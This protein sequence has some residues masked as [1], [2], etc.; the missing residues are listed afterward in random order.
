VTD[1]SARP[2]PRG[3]LRTHAWLIVLAMVVTLGGA[4]VVAFTRP[5]SYVAT[6]QVAVGPELAGG[7][8]LRPEM[9]SEREIATSGAVTARAANLLGVQPTDAAAGLSVSVVIESSILNIRYTAADATAASTG[10]S[11]FAQSYVDYRNTLGTGPRIARVVTQADVVERSGGN[12]PL[13]FGVALVA[14]LA[15]GVGAAWLWDR[16]ADRVRDPEELTERSG[17][18]VLAR[19]PRWSSD[20]AIAPDGPPGEAFGYVAARLSA[21]TSPRRVGVRIVVTSPRSG[22]GT[23]TVAMNTAFALAAQGRKVVLVDANLRNP[24]LHEVVG[25]AEAPGLLDVLGAECN[26]DSALRHLRRPLVDVLPIGGS[27]GARPSAPDIDVLRIILGQLGSRAVVVVDAP[28]VLESATAVLL[29]DKADV[30]LL[31]GNLRAG[32]RDDVG[33]AVRQLEEALPPVAG[34]VANLPRPRTAPRSGPPS[35]D[36]RAITARLPHLG[37]H[38]DRVTS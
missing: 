18:P 21:M 4:C 3:L 37:D 7:T 34:W 27:P 25:V 23:T 30:V 35:F 29:A 38:S 31:V 17:L 5:V 24:Q 36:L 26:L 8:A 20:G 15:L 6:A 28:P 16:L 19:I 1:Y 2:R 9:A 12:L 33:N 14:G 13:I 10:A 11:A 32:R 22:A